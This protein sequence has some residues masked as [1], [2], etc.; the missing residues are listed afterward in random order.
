[1]AVMTAPFSKMISEGEDSYDTYDPVFFIQ[2]TRHS[3]RAERMSSNKCEDSD[4]M[5]L[6]K[7]RQLS[8]TCRDPGRP[9]TVTRLPRTSSIVCCSHCLHRARSLEST[10]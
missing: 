6:P 2:G 10:S 9:T 8:G 4:S 5:L 1:M 3:N 7:R